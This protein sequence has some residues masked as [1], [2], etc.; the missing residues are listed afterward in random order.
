MLSWG[1]QKCIYININIFF[2]V[3]FLYTVSYTA[4]DL[5]ECAYILLLKL[6][7]SRTQ[8]KLIKN[9]AKVAI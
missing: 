5:L 3:Y 8:K 2:L 6:L 7:F 1:M 9:K 4:S